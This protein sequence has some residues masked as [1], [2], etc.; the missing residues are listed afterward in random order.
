MVI[1]GENLKLS[2]ELLEV[3]P[4]IWIKRPAFTHEVVN[5]EGAPGRAVHPETGLDLRVDFTVAHTC[6]ANETF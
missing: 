5:C 2:P 3:R 1:V 6:K 4:F